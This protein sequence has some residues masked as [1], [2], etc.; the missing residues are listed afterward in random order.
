MPK[1]KSVKMELKI[2]DEWKIVIEDEFNFVVQQLQST[3]LNKKTKKEVNCEMW[4][5]MG[6]CGSVEECV[7]LILKRFKDVKCKDLISYQKQQ[8]NLLEQIERTA[9]G[10]SAKFLKE[11]R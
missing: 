3:K 11:V 4:N 1:R 10:I 9:M 2:N 6:Y 5:D 8:K 7:K